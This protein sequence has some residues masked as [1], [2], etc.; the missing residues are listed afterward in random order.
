[1][2]K[3]F[4][5]AL[6]ILVAIGLYDKN[7]VALSADFI[8]TSSDIKHHQRLSENEVYSEFGCTGKNISPSLKWQNFPN[9]TKSFAITVFDPDAPTGLGGW[10]HWVMF[11]IP[12]DINQLPANAGNLMLNLAPEKSI[13]SNTDFGE[14]G[15]GG[16][17]PPIGNKLHRYQ[18]TVYA[19]DTED[20]A[21]DANVNP[22]TVG[23]YLQQHT[24][25]KATLEAYYS[26]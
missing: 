17:C 15:F 13:Q 11:N 3:L 20:L 24:L 18:F 4:V 22:A 1:M 6:I 14:P 25:N 26:R 21:L 19:L 9:D 2:K 7:H 23:F 8:V 10:V 12:V 5:L 16:A